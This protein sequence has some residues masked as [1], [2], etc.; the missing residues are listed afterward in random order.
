MDGFTVAREVRALPGMPGPLLVALTGYGQPED[1][2]RALE[3]G[4]DELMV[5]PINVQSLL[6]LIAGRVTTE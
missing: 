3:A 2:M 6:S 5:K 1:R 4:F